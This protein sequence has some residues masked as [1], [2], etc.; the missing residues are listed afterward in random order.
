MSYQLILVFFSRLGSVLFV[1]LRIQQNLL[2]LF[3]KEQLDFH[4]LNV[5]VIYKGKMQ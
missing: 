4:I 1:V 2:I 3:L 5:A